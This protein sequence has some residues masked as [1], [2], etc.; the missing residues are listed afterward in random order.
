M[1]IG[2]LARR[3]SAL[4]N[5]HQ[6]DLMYV[7]KGAFPYGPPVIEQ[8]LRSCRVPVIFDFDD[9]I[10]IHKKSCSHRILDH[11]KSTRRVG[12]VAAL[13]SRVVVPN[14]YLA[15]FAR[16]FNSNVTVVPEA[17][18]TQ[19]LIPRGPHTNN[20]QIIVG[21]VGSS[22]TAKYLTLIQE[23]LQTI[24]NRFPQ[25]TLQVIGG[26][27]DA[28]GIRTEI[29][30]WNFSREVQQFHGLDIGIMPL[31]LEEWS[32]GKSGCKLR[33]YM[34]TGVPGVGT[35]IGYNLELVDQGRTGFLATTQ[36]EWVEYLTKLIES[37]ELRNSIA[38]AA[39]ADIEQRFAVSII[40]P[41]LE[42]VIR[43]TVE[44]FHS[45]SMIGRSAA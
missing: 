42:T 33:Q 5:S 14:E 20:K 28:A 44:D 12:Q 24:C 13:A 21:W 43:K 7:L 11:L 26:K 25:V 9:A 37:A 18:D 10:H 36:N 30:D 23:A 16:Q 38:K 6:Y 31:P 40:G 45:T 19:R 29:L 4:L 39:R 22:S 34:A 15:E 41:Q 3:L 27:F 1:L 17:E 2:G 8:L 35:A 32:K